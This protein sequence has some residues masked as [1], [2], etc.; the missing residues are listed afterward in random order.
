MHFQYPIFILAKLGVLTLHLGS[1]RYQIHVLATEVSMKC[2]IIALK[3][4]HSFLGNLAKDTIRLL[5]IPF[6]HVGPLVYIIFT[7]S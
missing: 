7:S 2:L 3:S 5:Y 4:N 1:S 6:I